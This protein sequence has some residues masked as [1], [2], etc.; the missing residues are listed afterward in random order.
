[1][2]DVC[3]RMQALF[4]VHVCLAAM[5]IA[6]GAINENSRVS[7]ATRA[8]F[9]CTSMFHLYKHGQPDKLD[10]FLQSEIDRLKRQIAEKEAAVKAAQ[11]QVPTSTRVS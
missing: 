5:C 10:F 9:I 11:A 8:C 7:F 6:P 3:A 2:L 1:M 4:F